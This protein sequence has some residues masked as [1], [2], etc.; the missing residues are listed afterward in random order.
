MFV[1]IVTNRYGEQSVVYDD[2]GRD[3]Y[4]A[5][6]LGDARR[7]KAHCEELYGHWDEEPKYSVHLL[8]QVA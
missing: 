6:T 2:A 7:K 1:V 3:P 8:T 5:F 4:I